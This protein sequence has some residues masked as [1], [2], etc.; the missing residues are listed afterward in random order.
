MADL[1]AVPSR[2]RAAGTSAA[3][4]AEFGR[5]CSELDVRLSR[6]RT[7][8]EALALLALES[9]HISAAIALVALAQLTSQENP[10]S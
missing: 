9:Q 5:A 2:T 7:R 6:M 4:H 3:V 10:G 1:V 8:E